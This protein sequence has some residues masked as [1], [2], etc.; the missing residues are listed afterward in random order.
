LLVI[1]ASVF[2]RVPHATTPIAKVI[3]LAKWD[4]LC[5][6]PVHFPKEIGALVDCAS[7]LAT[8]NIVK[9]SHACLAVGKIPVETQTYMKHA[10][11][12]V[13]LQL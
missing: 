3:A 8:Y 9:V 2:R 5:T 12:L 10:R 4:V 1:C 6:A 13:K 11:P 7:V